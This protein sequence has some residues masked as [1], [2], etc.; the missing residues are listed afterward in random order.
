LLI[1]LK[2]LNEI[3]ERGF[4]LC[5]FSTFG[6]APRATIFCIIEHMSGAHPVVAGVASVYVKGVLGDKP[7]FPVGK[8]GTRTSVLV[9]GMPPMWVHA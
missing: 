7:I 8:R 1:S 6:T 5:K 9:T 3:K 4:F 2:S